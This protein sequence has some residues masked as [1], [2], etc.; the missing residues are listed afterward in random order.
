MAAA[1]ELSRYSSHVT[2]RYKIAQNVPF[3]QILLPQ[4]NFLGDH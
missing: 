3:T 4:G 2:K 1:C